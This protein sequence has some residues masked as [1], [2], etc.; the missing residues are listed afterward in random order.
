MR[1]PSARDTGGHGGPADCNPMQPARTDYTGGPEIRQQQFPNSTLSRRVRQQ[2]PACTAAAVNGD[3]LQSGEDGMTHRHKRSA[4]SVNAK[5]A[6]CSGLTI[7]AV[8][9]VVLCLVLGT[10]EPVYLAVP[11]FAIV[12][13]VLRLFLALSGSR[14]G[15]KPAPL[16]FTICGGEN[17]G[18]SVLVAALLVVLAPAINEAR[19]AARRSQCRNN[20]RQHSGCHPDCIIL[21][22][23]LGLE[24]VRVCPGCTAPEKPPFVVVRGDAGE[25]ARPDPSRG[26][27]SLAILQLGCWKL[28]EIRG[29]LRSQ[30]HA[31][32]RPRRAS[33]SGS[34]L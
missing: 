2:I 22:Q 27:P 1:N 11:F 15:R 9:G 16:S 14:R 8:G 28:A 3:A 17:L 32:H 20:L 23:S 7:G 13:M 18:T 19:D 29:T 6:L 31:I 25:L 21:D 33:P 10:L 34:S 5:R 26:M 24:G 30:E 12:G 4:G